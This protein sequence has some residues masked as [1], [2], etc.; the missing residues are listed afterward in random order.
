MRHVLD[1]ENRP[2]AGVDL[3]RDQHE[4]LTLPPAALRGLPD[5][6][7]AAVLSAAAAP[8]SSSASSP[9]AAAAVHLPHGDDRRDHDDDDRH[10]GH[11]H[12]FRLISDL[13]AVVSR[14]R[15]MVR[16]TRPLL[17]QDGSFDT[18]VMQRAA[19]GVFLTTFVRNGTASWGFALR[20]LALTADQAKAHAI[21]RRAVVA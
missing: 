7:E 3:A 18:L 8:R 17:G 1:S 6:L 16:E 2:D 10:W 4:H 14:L 12:L 20:T 15:T 21:T 9:A 19:V 11:G 13:H 5:F